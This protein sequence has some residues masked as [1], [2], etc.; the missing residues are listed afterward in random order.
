MEHVSLDDKDFE[1]LVQGKVIEKHGVQIALQD[2]GYDRMISHIEE[3][4][5][6][7]ESKKFKTK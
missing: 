1:Q 7:R 3:S 5:Y 6:Q 4:M 2:I